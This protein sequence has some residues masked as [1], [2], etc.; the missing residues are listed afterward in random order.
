MDIWA[1]YKKIAYSKYDQPPVFQVTDI[2][3][4][5]LLTEDIIQHPIMQLRRHVVETEDDYF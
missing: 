2:F 5:W 4:Q 3:Y 1:F